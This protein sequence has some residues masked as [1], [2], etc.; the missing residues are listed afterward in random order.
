MPYYDD[1][2]TDRAV[3]AY[4]ARATRKG[5]EPMQ[6]N[7]ALTERVR[8]RVFIRNGDS[9]EGLLATY[10]VRGNSVQFVS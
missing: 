1:E 2:I 5:Y 10:K 3:K 8:D 6:P 4:F 9:P 7:R